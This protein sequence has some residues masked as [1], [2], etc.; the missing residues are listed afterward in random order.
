[1]VRFSDT[2]TAIDKAEIGV[3][4]RELDSLADLF[5]DNTYKLIKLKTGKHWG[6]R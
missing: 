1:M 4:A 3:L 2:C 5:V 6:V